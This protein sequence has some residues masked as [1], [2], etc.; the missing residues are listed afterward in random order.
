[1][2]VIGNDTI[3]TKIKIKIKINVLVLNDSLA[4]QPTV[5]FSLPPHSGGFLDHTQ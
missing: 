3:K 1:V 4:L 2:T 5:G